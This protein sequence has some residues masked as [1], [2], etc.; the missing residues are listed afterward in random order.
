PTPPAPGRTAAASSG[1]SAAAL[2]APLAEAAL[3]TDSGGSIRIPAACCGVVGF[4]PTHELVSTAGCFPLAPSFD[5]VGPMARTVEECV[6]LLEAIAP[7]FIS[8]ELGSLEEIVVGTAW[9]DE[10]DPLVAE[11]VREA[12]GR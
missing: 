6:G 12:A 4:K 7:G 1:A 5:H 8:A 9:T 2:A 10:A 3:G 11:R